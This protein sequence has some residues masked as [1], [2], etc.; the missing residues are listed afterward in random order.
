MYPRTKREALLAQLQ[1]ERAITE[2]TMAAYRLWLPHVETAVTPALVADAGDMLPPDPNGVGRTSGVWTYTLDNMLVYGIGLIFAA[3]FLDAYADLTGG[4]TPPT[5]GAE[6]PQTVPLPPPGLPDAT[7]L[8]QRAQRIVA[9]R[10]GR[11]VASVRQLDTR[12]STIPTLRDRQSQ[13]MGNVFNR[14]VNT[15]DTVFRRIAADLDEGMA[16]GEGPFE[17]RHRVQT[18]LNT[19]TGDWPGRA[20]TVARTES[21]GTQS[22]ATLQAAMLQSQILGEDNLEQV[23]LCTLDSKTRKSHFAADGQRVPLGTTFKVGRAQLE[24]PADPSGPADETINCRCRV[25]V[26]ATDEDLP[27][28]TDRHTERSPGDSTVKNRDGSQA[29]EIERRAQDGVIRARDSDDGVGS[30]T[31]ALPDD[32]MTD[33]PTEEPHMT[34]YRSFT[35]VLAVIGQKTDDGRMFATDIDLQFREFPLPLLWQR[36]SNGGHFDS[37]TVGVIESAEV[38]GDKVVGSGYMLNTPEA[39]E[40]VEQA[41]HKV[42]APSVDLGD[43]SWLITDEA[44]NEIDWEDLWDDPSVDPDSVKVIETVTAAKLLGAT[45]VSI[46][47]FGQTSITIG[48]PVSKGPAEEQVAASLVASVAAQFAPATHP[49]DFFTDPKFS[50]PTL[51]HITADGRIQGHLATFNTCHVGIQDRC[52]MAPRS[53]TEYAWFHTAPTVLTTSGEQA[54]VGRLTVGGGHADG[55]LGVGPA[56]A[57]YDDVGTCF[58]LVHVGEDAH[59]IWFSGIPAPGATEEQ[60]AAGLSAPLSGDWRTVGGNLELVAALAVN[61]PGFPIVASGATDR[62]D[63]PLSLVASLGPCPDTADGPQM[64]KTQLTVFAKALFAEMRQSEKRSAAAKAAIEQVEGPRRAARK[65]A[66]LNLIARV[67][68]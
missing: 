61:T 38:D 12:I 14:M 45:L 36:Q 24:Y 7:E 6:Q 43:T 47:A 32:S 28:E 37:F 41:T 52:V 31:A 40:A 17:L 59:G 3:E 44:G 56:V 20:L 48:D 1:T 39:D 21:A 42:T 18:Y 60:V 29:D 25:A 50:G 2:L 67:E 10:M 49:D 57:H 62:T 58:A 16:G 15:P 54:K 55:R 66:A 33:E 53:S 19:E 8:A 23:W 65:S 27:D 35:S 68:G 26:L 64:S 5:D 11:T 34:D 13:Y 22:A 46:P 30:V 51:P 63:S 9:D 4:D